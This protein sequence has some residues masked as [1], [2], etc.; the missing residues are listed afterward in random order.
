MSKTDLDIQTFLSRWVF[1]WIL[2]F[3]SSLIF[4][5]ALMEIAF[6]A[7]FA[8]WLILKTQKRTPFIFK[9]KLFFPLAGFVFLCVLSFF[10]SEF[11]KESFRGV[12]KI[13]KQ[14]LI[15]WMAAETLSY[16]SRH[17]LADRTLVILFLV[18][19]VDGICQYIFGFDLIRHLPL[20][21]ASSGPR[22]SASFKNYG[23]LAAF[24]VTFLPLLFSPTEKGE[25]K[26]FSFL[27]I[28]GV[29][30][31]LQLIFWTRSRGA[32]VAFGGV[33]A[34]Y[35]AFEK[36]KIYLLLLGLLSLITLFLLP[37]SMLIHID[38]WGKEQSL[39]E[40]FYLWDRALQV[41]EARPLT[42]TGINTYA[43]AHQAFDKRRS[44][45]V[46]NYYAHNGYMQMAAETGLPSLFF[47][48]AFIF[49]Y[50]K[51]AFGAVKIAEGN[52]R[53]KLVGMLAG[54]WGFLI[55]CGIDTVFHNPQVVM[56]FWFLAGWG[57]ACQ[58]R[59]LLS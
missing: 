13:L 15:F 43:V 21:L 34:F 31:G 40:R 35:L 52:S 56:G 55:L 4:S 47:F 3:L 8:G 30:L 32:W 23:L 24:V 29:A 19:G 42:G 6:A 25:K 39:I 14:F 12:F 26:R 58:E 1:V 45:R 9:W 16:P 48:L 41:I 11:P 10:W 17:R 5:I 59:Q 28:L 27:R 36:K 20:E 37:R 54:I 2:I 18:L 49:L 7:A 44:W 57:V 33:L 51:E 38:Y 46:R 50:F 53:R 22:V